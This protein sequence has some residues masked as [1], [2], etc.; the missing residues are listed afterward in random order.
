MPQAATP[1]AP[2]KNISEKCSPK[3]FGEPVNGTQLMI[4]DNLAFCREYYSLCEMPK[5][6]NGEPVKV[7]RKNKSYVEIA[8]RN[9]LSEPETVRLAL[10]K[11]YGKMKEE[12][13]DKL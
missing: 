13:K 2:K 1:S 4:A 11:G 8:M 5:D 3:P 12:L 10:Q 7:R 6:K 9:E